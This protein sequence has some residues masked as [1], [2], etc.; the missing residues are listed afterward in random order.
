LGYLLLTV[1]VMKGVVTYLMLKIVPVF[2]KM[3]YEFELPLPRPTVTLIDYSYEMVQRGWLITPL[4]M[5]T[6]LLLLVTFHTGAFR[7]AA[8]F[9]PRLEWFRRRQH[10]AWLLTALAAMV[11]Q[12]RPLP[13]SLAFLADRYPTPFI[14]RRLRRAVVNME[15]GTSWIEAL[16]RR[17]FIAS[18][19][20]ALIAASERNGHLAWGMET[21]AAS[22]ERRRMARLRYWSSAIFPPAIVGLGML[23]GYVVVSLM[24]PLIA[25][26]AGLAR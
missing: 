26:I 6:T 25:L 24:L 14:A 1:V 13:E 2:A 22:L 20:A 5:F 9:L 21:V 15:G 4:L 10:G 23:I 12:Q 17:G 8:F 16:Q 11:R 18:Y 7:V 3:F 19:D